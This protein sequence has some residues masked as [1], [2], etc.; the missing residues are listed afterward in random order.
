MSPQNGYDF[1]KDT[2][3]IRWVLTKEFTF[4]QL[5]YIGDISEYAVK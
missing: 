5:P 1:K 3:E 4:D 2:T